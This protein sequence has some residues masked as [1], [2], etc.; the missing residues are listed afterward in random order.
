MLSFTFSIRQDFLE[1]FKHILAPASL[2]RFRKFFR[3][4]CSP[5]VR[6]LTCLFPLTNKA[7]QDAKQ[8]TTNIEDNFIISIKKLNKDILLYLQNM[9]LCFWSTLERSIFNYMVTLYRYSRFNTYIS[10]QKDRNDVMCLALRYKKN[11]IKFTKFCLLYNFCPDLNC[12][13]LLTAFC[14]N[15][16]LFYIGCDCFLKYKTFKK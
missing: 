13:F 12:L 2:F 10:H 16:L 7:K 9:Q 8:P 3:S 11:D 15:F 14:N 1:F 5:Q 4:A 6:I